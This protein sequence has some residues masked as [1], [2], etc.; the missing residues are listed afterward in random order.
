VNLGK[1]EDVFNV[2][3]LAQSFKVVLDLLNIAGICYP[4]ESCWKIEFWASGWNEWT[5]LML[6][7]LARS[8][9][10][11]SFLLTSLVWL[12]QSLLFGSNPIDGFENKENRSTVQTGW[13]TG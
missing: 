4:E 10:G 6:N 2:A 5:M 11:A 13:T 12:R 8:L 7:G 3:C 9:R 1:I